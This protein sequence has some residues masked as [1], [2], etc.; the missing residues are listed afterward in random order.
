MPRFDTHLQLLD[1]SLQRTNSIFVYDFAATRRVAGVQKLAN[2]W[3]KCFYT[4]KGS[5]PFR[6]KE[7]TDYPY[8]IGGNNIS[9]LPSLE[10]AILTHIEDASDQIRAIDDKSPWLASNERLREATLV[11]FVQPTPDHI[12]FWVQ[13]KSVTGEF[14]NQLIPYAVI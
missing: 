9:D 7:G 8:L 1:P 14:L 12:E 6:P 10:G 5:H 4:P 3:L 13:V 2:R 11:R